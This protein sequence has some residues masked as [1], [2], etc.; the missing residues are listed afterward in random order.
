[1]R[2]SILLGIHFDPRKVLNRQPH[3]DAIASPVTAHLIGDWRAAK[4]LLPNRFPLSPAPRCVEGPAVESAL[5]AS[6]PACGRGGLHTGPS[7]PIV[8]WRTA[9]RLL[10]N[11]VAVFKLGDRPIEPF[12]PVPA[13]P[14]L[15][16]LSGQLVIRPV[17]VEAF[18]P[19]GA[20]VLSQRRQPARVEVS[21]LRPI[22]TIDNRKKSLHTIPYVLQ[23]VVCYRAAS[24]RSRCFRR[25]SPADCW[26][27]FSHDHPAPGKGDR[28]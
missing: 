24:L 25:R 1:M 11:G 23:D 18:Q 10:P 3:P 13:K 16:R 7:I 22:D 28:S 5:P 17:V 21:L 19:V 26:I 9:D 8:G 4:P 15:Q 20:G 14:G 27:L 12:N 6:A 2:V